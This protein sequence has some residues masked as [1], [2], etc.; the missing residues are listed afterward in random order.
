VQEEAENNNKSQ[1]AYEFAPVG[2]VQIPHPTPTLTYNQVPTQSTTEDEWTEADVFADRRG[3]TPTDTSIEPCIIE[4]DLYEFGTSLNVSLRTKGRYHTWWFSIDDGAPRLVIGL[5]NVVV[6]ELAL[7]SH[8]IEIYLAGPGHK[9][10]QDPC[11]TRKLNFSIGQDS[12]QVYVLENCGQNVYITAIHRINI[13]NFAYI[14]L[15]NDEFIGCW[16]FTDLDPSAIEPLNAEPIDISQ[17]IVR[18]NNLELKSQ[19]CSCCEQKNCETEQIVNPIKKPKPIKGDP[20]QAPTTTETRELFNPPNIVCSAE[21]IIKKQDHSNGAPEL[22]S[23]RGNQEI[24]D[25]YL[26]V[27]GCPKFITREKYFVWFRRSD[28]CNEGWINNSK[29]YTFEWISR[30]ECNCD[31][32]LI[33]ITQNIEENLAK[34]PLPGEEDILSL[35][36]NENG[37]PVY[38]VHMLI[39]T[40]KDPTLAGK[41]YYERYINPNS[42]ELTTTLIA[43]NNTEKQIATGNLYFSPSNKNPN[44]FNSFHAIDVGKTISRINKIYISEPLK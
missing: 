25:A 30:E 4:V 1:F 12:T 38:I 41:E 10:Y 35:K 33:P 13:E 14:D 22:L 20:P 43:N 31:P 24:K 18:Y 29:A 5:E 17:Q 16:V 28:D 42:K 3:Y 40:Q 2:Y 32:Y 34:N 11:T 8:T 23:V 9:R 21:L 15:D 37:D 26:N 19:A 6:S 44:Y 39:S 27:R 36:L 7:G